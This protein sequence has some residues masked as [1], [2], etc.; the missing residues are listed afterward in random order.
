M[1]IGGS[2][3]AVAALGLSLGTTTPTATVVTASSTRSTLQSNY[4]ALLTQI[5]QLA[6]DSSYNGVNLLDRQQPD[7]QLQRDGTSA[8]TIARRQLQLD[9]DL[10]CRRLNGNGFQDNT[11]ITAT[12][13][14]I[15]NAITAVRAQTQ[16]FGTNSSTISDPADV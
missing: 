11:T 7:G 8:L 12:E 10:D 4:N 2:A 3:S 5:D 14:A 9:A 16:T 1:T 6:G 15:N 13:T